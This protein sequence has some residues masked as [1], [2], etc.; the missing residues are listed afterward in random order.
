[1]LVLAGCATFPSGIVQINPH[2]LG[3]DE[4]LVKELSASRMSYVFRGE[5]GIYSFDIVPFPQSVRQVQFIFADL[6]TLSSLSIQPPGGTWTSLYEP[7]APGP[8]GVDVARKE[9]DW[10]AAFSG[11]GLDLLRQGGRFQVIDV[12]RE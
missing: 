10:C 9:N 5:R 6:R 2:Y 4:V 3:P 12:Y 1:M 11:T 8:G 7:N